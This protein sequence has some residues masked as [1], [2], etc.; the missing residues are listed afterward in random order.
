MVSLLQGVYSSSNSN[1][2]ADIK[3]G[4]QVDPVTQIFNRKN[5]AHDR[6]DSVRGLFLLLVLQINSFFWFTLRGDAMVILLIISIVV[7]AYLFYALIKP[8]KF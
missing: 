5:N 3:S 6:N 4:I 2:P 1:Y 7:F 8:E